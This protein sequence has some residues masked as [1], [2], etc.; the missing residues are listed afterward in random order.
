[1][2]PFVV[3]LEALF[4]LDASGVIVIAVL[5]KLMFTLALVPNHWDQTIAH[6]P[7][8]RVHW[9]DLLAVEGGGKWIISPSMLRGARDDLTWRVDTC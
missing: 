2:F 3:N 5:V 1:M 7:S 4:N 6:R 9:F 8:D